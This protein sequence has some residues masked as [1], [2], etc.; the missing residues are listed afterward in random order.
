[1]LRNTVRYLMLL[2]N[3]M[4]ETR[5]ITALTWHCNKSAKESCTS[6]GRPISYWSRILTVNAN[7]LHSLDSKR[8]IY[9]LEDLTKD[10][11]EH[12]ERSKARFD[13][14]SEMRE[15]I[16]TNFRESGI[17]KLLNRDLEN[18]ILIAENKKHLEVVADI[19][20]AFFEDNYRLNA[21]QKASLIANFLH[22]CHRL[23]ELDISK[24][25]WNQNNI[26]ELGLEDFK[27]T[28]IFY[29]SYLFENGHYKEIIEYYNKL[30]DQAKDDVE[31]LSV[32]VLAALAKIETKAA[33]EQ[34]CDILDKRFEEYSINHKSLSASLC[35]WVAYKLKN[36]GFAYDILI[37]RVDENMPQLDRFKGVNN[38]KLAILLEI[39]K[40]DEVTI[41]LRKLL[42]SA[43]DNPNRKMIICF[44]VMKKYT[45]A[46]KKRNE[47]K[48]TTNAIQ[49][50][51]ELDAKTE[52]TDLP[53]EELVFAK[54]TINRSPKNNEQ[55]KGKTKKSTSSSLQ[56]KKN[57]L[58]K[59]YLTCNL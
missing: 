38:M 52:L 41:F 6:S 43:N 59:S 9:S 5:N 54:L 10:F 46:I 2:P 4:K 11:C 18:L 26:N 57:K 23:N 36:F 55:G 17:T 48:F 31:P 14:M 29:F 44:N 37:S 47:Q 21:V 19:I 30:S 13:N 42:R 15:S 34:M 51:Q 20:S 24:E 58:S 39:E 8:D 53:L 16:E 22:L 27:W 49:I 25:F 45:D 28:R 3:V 12:Q 50:C 7:A 33:L 40:I 56:T 1:M 35:S 32:V